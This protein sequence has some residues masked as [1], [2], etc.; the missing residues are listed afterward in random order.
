MTVT[1]EAR[2]NTEREKKKN[3]NTVSASIPSVQF[4]V[5][6]M[7]SRICVGACVCTYVKNKG[8]ML[9]LPPRLFVSEWG[10]VGGFYYTCGVRHNAGPRKF[11][12]LFDG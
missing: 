7:I 5:T 10:V 2:Q 11:R 4:H 12:G 9:V 8:D 3:I 6:E 1:M